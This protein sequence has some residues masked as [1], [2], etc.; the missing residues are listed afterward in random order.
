MPVGSNDHQVHHV[1]DQREIYTYL[2]ERSRLCESHSMLSKS[3]WDNPKKSSQVKEI[4]QKKKKYGNTLFSQNF[5]FLQ[6][7]V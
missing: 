1:N 4:Q 2:C 5:A 7:I 6:Y 3:D